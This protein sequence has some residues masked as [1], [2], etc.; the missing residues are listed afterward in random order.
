MEELLKMGRLLLM[1]LNEPCSAIPVFAN[2]EGSRLS[3]SNELNDNWRKTEAKGALLND[4][5]I[6][7]L[8]SQ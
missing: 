2:S 4:G 6:G 3:T 5:F 8:I 7:S 1:L